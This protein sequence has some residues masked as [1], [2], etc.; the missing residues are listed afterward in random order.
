MKKR[1]LRL[2]RMVAALTLSFV[3]SAC[4]GLRPHGLTG[5][6]WQ[7]H[8]LTGPRDVFTMRNERVPGS[9]KDA[10]EAKDPTDGL[11]ISLYDF[12]EGLHLPIGLDWGP[13]SNDCL[14][15]ICGVTP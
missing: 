15:G 9:T 7:P 13:W 4:T 12:L 10:F 5:T 8:G 6:G 3:M 11:V 1:T 2:E 14:A